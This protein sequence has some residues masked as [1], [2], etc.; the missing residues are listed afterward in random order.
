MNRVLMCAGI[1]MLGLSISAGGAPTRIAFTTDQSLKTTAYCNTNMLAKFVNAVLALSP[2]PQAVVEGGDLINSATDADGFNCYKLFT[3]AMARLPAAG[4]PYYSAVGNHDASGDT[5]GWYAKWTNAF[6]YFPA[7][8]PPQW[9]K[10]AYYVDTGSCRLVFLDCI[11]AGTN[12]TG[13]DVDKVDPVQRAWLQSVIGTNSPREF[14]IVIVHEPAFLAISADNSLADHPADRDALVQIL[15]DSKASALLVGHNHTPCRR[16][17]DTRYNTNWVWTVPQVMDVMG[18]TYDLTP[19]STPPLPDFIRQFTNTFTVFDLDPATQTGTG[20]TYTEDGQLLLDQ[21]TVYG[22]HYAPAAV[23]TNRTLLVLSDHGTAM[24]PA[25]THT[26][27]DGDMLSCSIMDPSVT[28]GATQYVC[29]GWAGTGS[30][31]PAL[32]AGTNTPLFAITNDST[33]VWMWQTNYLLTT[34]AS[35]PG[36]IDTGGW[37]CAGSNVQITAT[38][39]QYYH[40]YGWSGDTNECPTGGAVITV[41]MSAPRRITADFEANK[42][43]KGTPE[44]WLA[45]NGL[46]N[47]SFADAELTDDDGDRMQAWQEYQCDTVPTDPVS[48][49]AISAVLPESG[50]TRI[51]W[52]GGTHITEHLQRSA[53][54]SATDE[55]VSVF[56]SIAPTSVSNDYVDSVAGNPSGMFYRVTVDVR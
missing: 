15:S 45:A 50:G 52:H 48:D 18:S 56:T 22:K 25:G 40:F 32:G 20:T 1:G 17:L 10:L 43:P 47:G 28:S 9:S 44:W 39:D 33:I 7:N 3:N 27:Q 34:A 2:A 5:T 4:I 6:S 30:V 49:L 24:P 11:T 26:N 37:F 13:A 12:S 55:W 46:T 42:A 38:P 54:I 36:S 41:P 53:G 31:S 16:M 14:D 51:A 35:G 19:N 23:V 8:G 21:F 29:T